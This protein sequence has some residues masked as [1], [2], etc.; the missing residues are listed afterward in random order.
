MAA[1]DVNSTLACAILAK[2]AGI[3]VAYV[4]AGLRS[5]DMGMPEEINCIVTDSISDYQTVLQ[6][7][8]ARAGSQVSKGKDSSSAWAASMRST[9][10]R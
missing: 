4:E 1:F 6:A 7:N 3:P 5:G 8:A 10:S 2:K 9:G